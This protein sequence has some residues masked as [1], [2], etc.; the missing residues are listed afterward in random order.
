MRNL[1]KTG[2]KINSKIG[3]AIHDYKL[4]NEGDRILI[5][6]S[7]GK[8]SIT[9]LHFL[10]NIQ[11]W[12]PVKFDLSAIHIQ[13]DLS[14]GGRVHKDFLSKMFEN[15][16]IGCT[17]KNI[18]VLDEKGKTSCFWCAWNRRK[19][20]FKFAEETK[21]NKIALGHHKDDIA[22]TILMNLLYKGEISAM[23]P[24]QE[25]FDGKLTIVRP[26]CYVEEDMIIKFAK[27]NG[28]REQLFKC[29]YGKTSQRKY[30]KDFIRE[31]EQKLPGVNIKTNIF[32]GPMR[33]KEEY[34]N[35]KMEK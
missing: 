26:L 14:C 1:T 22:E 31:T 12:A 27:E 8:D 10:K 4:I 2:S 34:I 35:L 20:I 19:T 24:R 17:V 18:K 3:K 5:A 15:L 9:L 33:V 7:G 11:S 16:D 28:F 29:P 30:I 23:N 13:T 21:C 32:N 6:V 25:L